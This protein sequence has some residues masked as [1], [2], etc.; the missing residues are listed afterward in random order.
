MQE[1][2]MDLEGTDFEGYHEQ[3]EGIAFRALKDVHSEFR[4]SLYQ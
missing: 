2:E 3:F 4:L 1:L